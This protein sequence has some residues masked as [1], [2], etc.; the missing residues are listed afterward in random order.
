MACT[1]G[2]N[3]GTNSGGPHTL[4]YGVTVNHTLGVT[5][6]LADGRVVELGSSSEDGPGYDL[7]GVT[8]GSEGTFGIITEVYVRL[9]RNAPS[10][11]T[12]LGIY[13]S[14]D[15]ATSTVSGIIAAGM[16]KPWASVSGCAVRAVSASTP[17]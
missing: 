8:V 17:D 10:V 2:G 3:V 4:K 6:V 16:A 7:V 15:D 9:T 1:I 13:D 12:L 5:M 14:I 11:R